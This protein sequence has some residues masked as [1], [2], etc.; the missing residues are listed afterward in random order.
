MI[1]TGNLHQARAV[2]RANLTLAE[3]VH[4]GQMLAAV[5]WSNQLISYITGDWDGVRTFGDR[6]LQTLPMDPRL[7]GTRVVMEYQLGAF[8]QGKSYMDRLL[9]AVHSTAPGPNLEY[10]AA[11]MVAPIIVQTG[12][13]QIKL[14][15]LDM[16]PSGMP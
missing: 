15:S 8:N 7:L 10:T 11:V 5:L 13:S 16:D 1:T 3:Q 6:G 9:E 4:N 2:A 12:I 14:I